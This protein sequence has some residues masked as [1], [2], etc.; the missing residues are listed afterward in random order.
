MNKSLILRSDD[1]PGKALEMD[2]NNT[3]EPRL[4]TPGVVADELGVSLQRVLYILSTRQHIKPS[5]R[6]GT[7][8]LYDSKALEL[9]R[10]ELAE[11]AT[12]RGESD[13]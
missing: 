7:L 1:A 2:D 5:A 8:R 3:S 6:A 10:R 4:R 11:I 9:I 13:E 12:R